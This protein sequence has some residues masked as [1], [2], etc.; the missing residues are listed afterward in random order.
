M[1]EAVPVF[2]G[3]DLSEN[4]QAMDAIAATGPGQHF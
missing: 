2:E 1:R 3:I 4:A